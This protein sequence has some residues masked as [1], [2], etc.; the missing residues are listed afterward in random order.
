MAM[1]EIDYNFETF[2]LGYTRS[3]VQPIKKLILVR[4]SF[5]PKKLFL[6]YGIYR[7][8]QL[9]FLRRKKFDKSENWQICSKNMW[10]IISKVPENPSGGLSTILE[11]WRRKRPENGL[12][13]L[14]H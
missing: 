1:W 8:V 7:L 5:M 13:L 10:N 14:S 9:R 2:S 12:T 3:D 4:Y 6:I 11:K